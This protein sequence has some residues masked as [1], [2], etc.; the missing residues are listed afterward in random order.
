[1]T[2]A[3]SPGLYPGPPHPPVAAGLVSPSPGVS[4]HAAPPHSQ[5]PGAS[6]LLQG[7]LFPCQKP[8]HCEGPRD[9]RPVPPPWGDWDPIPRSGGT[10]PQPRDP[11][12]HLS[13]GTA[14]QD[15]AP[16]EGQ[17]RGH[18]LTLT[19]ARWHHHGRGTRRGG[20]HGWGWGSGLGYFSLFFIYKVPGRSLWAGGCGTPPGTGSARGLLPACQPPPAAESNN[21]INNSDGKGESAVVVSWAARPG[22][23]RGRGLC[24][25]HAG[26]GAVGVG[27]PPGHHQGPDP[28]RGH[29]VQHRSGSCGW[30]APDVELHIWGENAGQGGER[31]GKCGGSWVPPEHPSRPR[32]SVLPPSIPVSHLK[33]PSCSGTSPHPT[34][35]MAP[36][37]VTPWV[38]RCLSEAKP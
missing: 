12:G 15:P 24:C 9:H 18:V 28:A 11:R 38:S 30:A 26:R 21:N 27:S 34:L 37:A 33:H 23:Q 7:L 13:L 3:L 10:H 29:G 31:A 6:A 8:P 32:A 16:S 2:H 5:T 4:P 35:P 36:A 1:M 25:P 17:R 14:G 19:R 22:G 20:G